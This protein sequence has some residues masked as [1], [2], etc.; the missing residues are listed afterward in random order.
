MS[1]M[2]ALIKRTTRVV[3][4]GQLTRTIFRSWRWRLS[5]RKSLE[6]ALF[7]QKQ[8]IRLYWSYSWRLCKGWHTLRSWI[9]SRSNDEIESA[10]RKRR[11]WY[12]TSEEPSNTI[13][14]SALIGSIQF[15]FG[16][17]RVCPI[18]SVGIDWG[19]MDVKFGRG[20]RIRLGDVRFSL[21]SKSLYTLSL[22]RRRSKWEVRGPGARILSE[23][24]RGLNRYEMISMGCFSE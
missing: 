24:T 2:K 6:Q 10:L 15:V 14:R 12:V 21:V 17:R 23:E 9:R 18:S 1:M 7:S 8:L 20:E 22:R 5:Y 16:C 4:Q 3:R 11:N 19:Q 13:S